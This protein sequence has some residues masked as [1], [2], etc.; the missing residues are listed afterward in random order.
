MTDQSGVEPL[1]VSVHEA[2]RMIGVCPRSVQNYV[3]SKVLT[4]R[5]IGRRRV[6]TVA[7]LKDFLRRDQPSPSGVKNDATVSR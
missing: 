4:S 6:I 3:A 1:A 2:A 5:K 7:A